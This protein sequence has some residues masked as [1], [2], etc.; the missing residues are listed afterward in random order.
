V[1]VCCFV[2]VLV[3]VSAGVMVFVQHDCDRL[4]CWEISKVSSYSYFQL[5]LSEYCETFINEQY[6]T[7]ERAQREEEERGIGTSAHTHK[8]AIML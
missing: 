1:F 8:I 6:V 7:S 5:L 3:D 4:A 2:A